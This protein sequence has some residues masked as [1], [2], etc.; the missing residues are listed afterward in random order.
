MLLLLAVHH[1]RYEPE[2]AVLRMSPATVS[3]SDVGAEPIATLEP[4]SWIDHVPTVLLLVNRA[5]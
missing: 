5:T 4:L 1:V 2:L 3:L